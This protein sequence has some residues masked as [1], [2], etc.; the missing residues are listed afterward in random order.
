MLINLL[1]L[2]NPFIINKYATILIKLSNNKLHNIKFH[3]A[4]FTSSGIILYTNNVN[5]FFKYSSKNMWLIYIYIFFLV[6]QINH[7]YC[8]L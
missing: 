2:S 1:L 5:N 3:K 6:D 7:E 4:N 8:D